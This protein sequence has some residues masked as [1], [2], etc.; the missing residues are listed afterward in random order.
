MDSIGKVGNWFEFGVGL[1][2]S[3]KTSKHAVPEVGLERIPLNSQWGHRPKKKGQFVELGNLKPSV[4]LP[5]EP[6][7]IPEHNVRRKKKREGAS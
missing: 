5:G 2:A 7:K 4:D 3:G 1:V 6:R